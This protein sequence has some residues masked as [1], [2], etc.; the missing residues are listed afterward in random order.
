MEDRHAPHSDPAHVGSEDALPAQHAWRPSTTPCPE[1]GGAHVLRLD[2]GRC[3]LLTTL[4]AA[5]LSG[6][7]QVPELPVAGCPL[8]KDG[9]AKQAAHSSKHEWLAALMS[10]PARAPGNEGNNGYFSQLWQR[11]RQ[12]CRTFSYAVVVTQMQLLEHVSSEH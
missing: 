11:R 4:R 1:V 2:Q 8:C 9:K 12:R 6:A 10:P 7:C 3:A 5:S